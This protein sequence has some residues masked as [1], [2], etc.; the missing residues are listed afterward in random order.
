MT[1]ES[2]LITIGIALAA[3]W[4]KQ[5][6]NRLDEITSAIVGLKTDVAVHGERINTHEHRL[7]KLEKN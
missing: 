6:L 3:A 1:V 5:V 7:E 2:I 4:G